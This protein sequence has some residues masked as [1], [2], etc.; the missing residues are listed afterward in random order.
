M[1]TSLDM[2]A[3]KCMKVE[4]K[5]LNKE[6]LVGGGVQREIMFIAQV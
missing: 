6:E 5:R 3:C 4:I 1:I 2:K